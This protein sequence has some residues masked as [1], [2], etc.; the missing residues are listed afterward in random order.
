MMDYAANV[1]G[2]LWF[3]ENVWPLVRRRFPDAIFQIVGRNPTPAVKALGRVNG[4][5][6]RGAVPDVRPFLAKAAIS[7]APL[8]VARGVQNK[9]LESLSMRKA[10]V[11]SP[12]ALSGLA[13]QPGEELLCAQTVPEWIDAIGQL[14]ANPERRRE[15]GQAGRE[16]V[17]QYHNWDECLAPYVE[18]VSSTVASHA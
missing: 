5:E 2:V 1:E 9:I 3:A 4:I 6:V 15:L 11:V 18:M 10:M 14:L 8:R 12:E 7:I 13:A 17:K 16:Y